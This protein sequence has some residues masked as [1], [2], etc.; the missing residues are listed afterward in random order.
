[1]GQDPKSAEAC[2]TNA[3]FAWLISHQPAV[4]FSHNK[5]ATSNQPAVLFS[6]NKPAPAISHQPNEQAVSTH[7]DPGV[8]Y[9][10]SPVRPFSIFTPVQS[11]SN[12]I[13]SM[14]GWLVADG[15]CWFV[16]REEYCWLV[17]GLF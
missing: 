6:Q 16:L 9:P 5:P 15:G 17:A 2:Q 12:K 4:L 8:F 1:V 7:K 3:V 14:F 13:W 10:L 11:E